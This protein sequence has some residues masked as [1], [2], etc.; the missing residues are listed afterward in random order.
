[1]DWKPISEAIMWDKINASY[2]RMC[3]EQRKLW[4][5][6]KIIPEKWQQEPWGNVGNGFWVVA[7]I[8]N[9]II[10]YNDIEEGFNRSTYSKFGIINEYGC[11]QDNLEWQIQN[12]IN[13]IKGL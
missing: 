1:V 6:I 5:V 4:E 7:I 3:L 2:D 13:E 11:N 8:G 9:S 10:W 12:L